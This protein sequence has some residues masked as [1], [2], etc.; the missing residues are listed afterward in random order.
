MEQ[1]NL[2]NYEEAKSILLDLGDF[3]D[4]KTQIIIVEALT[5]AQ[6][7]DYILAIST[8]EEIGD[9]EIEYDLDGGNNLQLTS[10]SLDLLLLDQTPTK[11]GYVFNDW[12]LIDFQVTNDKKEYKANVIL[13]ATYNME[14]YTIHY[15]LN[16]GVGVESQTYNIS[17]EDFLLDTPTKEGYSFGGWYET[18]SLTGQEVSFV[19][20]GNIGDYH[21]YAK[22]IPNEYRISFNTMGGTINQDYINVTYGLE[23]TLPTPYRDDYIFDGWYHNDQNIDNGVWEISDN[24]ELEA[25]WI[26][27]YY[28]VFF[29]NNIGSLYTGSLDVVYNEDYQLPIPSEEN[30]VFIGWFRNEEL[31]SNNGKWSDTKD[32]TLVAKW[33]SIFTF[34]STNN[35]V[36]ITG[37]QN[38]F[39]NEILN[40]P[41]EIF[42]IKVTEI[43][44][45]SNDFL[46]QVTHITIPNSVEKI[47]HGAFFGASNLQ[48]ITIPFVGDS[49][50]H[51]YDS[52]FG[53]I[54][55][56]KEFENT[57]LVWTSYDLYYIPNTLKEII[58][59]DSEVIGKYA[60]YDLESVETI[61]IPQNT[62]KIEFNAFDSLPNLEKLV[63]PL[64]V[65]IIERFA[66]SLGHKPIYIENESKPEGWDAD[67]ESRNFNLIWN[68][69]E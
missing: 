53:Y 38:N 51:V 67:F 35:Q 65:T 50:S 57:Y 49:R 2:G 30:Y 64:S 14:I 12:K 31:F 8:F 37:F 1:I 4:A 42:G 15:Y 43:N 63:I 56:N 61:I 18:P 22:W 13:K 27:K 25:R 7:G 46:N 10:L 19:P 69:S 32:I 54:F 6:E 68:Y 36:T 11:T 52:A 34:T 45:Q 21:F 28:Q 44:F 66:I 58:V 23:V 9:V 26:Y 33:E 20:N 3:S 48:S 60:F 41:N 55:G 29:E 17:S 59:N 47:S 39:N 24:I 40:F 16:G 5:Y 62:T